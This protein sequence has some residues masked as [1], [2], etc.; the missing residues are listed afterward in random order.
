MKK[1]HIKN[2]EKIGFHKIFCKICGDYSINRV[3][4]NYS[5]YCSFTTVSV[6]FCADNVVTE[7][8]IDTVVSWCAKV[9]CRNY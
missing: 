7:L 2:P 4:Y 9:L 5:G 6:T 1:K 3:H 8:I